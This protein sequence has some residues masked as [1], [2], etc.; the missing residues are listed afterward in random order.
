MN[1]LEDD[2][3]YV[4][5]KS[6]LGN[7]LTPVSAAARAALPIGEVLA[8]AQGRFCAA[9]ARQLA[10][11]LGLNA[12]AFACLPD[13][14]PPTPVVAGVQRIDLP[15]GDERV[16]AWRIQTGDTYILFD[17][18][19]APKDLLDILAADGGRM[20]DHVFITHAHCDHVGAV[21][22]LLNAGVTVHA[23][24]IAG[25]VPISPGASVACGPLTIRACDLAGHATPACGF[26]IEGLAQPVLVTGDALF[27][28]SM[29]GCTS[30]A[31]YQ[32]ALCRLH[33]VLDVLEDT[34]VL[35]PGHGPSTTLGTE[36]QA[37]PFL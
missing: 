26:H 36:R 21:T 5:R 1:T 12:D 8:F 16:N 25:T 19:Y 34:T 6:L 32:H 23:A 31:A 35:L 27:A 2:F 37:N 15:F 7:N 9:T 24:G 4:L 29:G 10:A 3:T 11:V 22:A 30:P 14:Q 33:A 20:P 18:G 13:Y 28:G 17:A